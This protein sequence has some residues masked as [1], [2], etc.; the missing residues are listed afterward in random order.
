MIF[1]FSDKKIIEMYL[2]GTNGVKISNL[3]G[4]SSTPIY[5]FLESKGIKRRSNSESQRKYCLDQ[6]YFDEIDTE[7]KAYFLG[8]LYADGYN[9]E[10]KGVVVLGLKKDDKEILEKFKKE[11][12]TNKPLQKVKTNKYSYSKPS[13]SDQ[14]RVVI[15]SKHISEKLK[16][17]GCMQK[18][19][20]L[21]KFPFW[22]NKN[23]INHFIRGY[24]DGD[25]YIGV[26][27]TG[28]A[29]FYLIG[30]ENFC[31]TLKNIFHTEL[32]VRAFITNTTNSKKVKQLG[33][34]NK[35]GI[36]ELRNWFYNDAY[37]YLNRKYKTF[38]KV[39]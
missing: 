5:S 14:Y 24:F 4:C 30:T 12:K 21:L 8:L 13:Y 36:L 28:R 17:F 1:P 19:S 32:K 34:C 33:V 11:L 20:L 15:C 3:C 23:L 38:L 27:K 22:L 2:S 10:D 7:G 39:R 9:N 6:N 35:K 25:G 16:E 26:R 29:D 31:K 37:F 18:K